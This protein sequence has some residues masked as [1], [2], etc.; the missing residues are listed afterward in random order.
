MTCCCPEQVQRSDD[1]VVI[2]SHERRPDQQ[3]PR[4]AGAQRVAIVNVVYIGAPES[5][6]WILVDTGI[7]G[8]PPNDR[9]AAETR[10]GGEPPPSILLTHG[11]FDHIGALQ[12]LADQWNVLIL[13]YELEHLLQV[14]PNGEQT[15]LA[16]FGSAK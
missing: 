9:R 6:G 7:S 14:A 8:S 4:S 2:T 15:R 3:S 16:R 10:F 5:G 11:N 1:R 12:T 13:A